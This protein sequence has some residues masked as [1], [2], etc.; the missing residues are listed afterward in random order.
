MGVCRI[1]FNQQMEFAAG[2]P[3][4]GVSA[5]GQ[6]QAAVNI[7]FEFNRRYPHNR[8]IAIT[9]LDQSRD[10]APKHSSGKAL[11]HVVK[12]AEKGYLVDNCMSAGD[13]SVTVEG[14]E[15]EYKVCPLSSIGALTVAHSLNELTIRELVRRGHKHL[16]LQNMHLGQTQVKYEE[17]LANQRRRYAK[18]LSNLLDSRQ[19]HE[20]PRQS[21]AVTILQSVEG[22]GV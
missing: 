11:Y 22:R 7:A 16:V 1:V 18:A 9:S 14:R 2:E 12:Q 17:G 13:V 5:T 10:A 3:L 20:C 6:T 21:R 8:P 19:F 4:I 15:Q